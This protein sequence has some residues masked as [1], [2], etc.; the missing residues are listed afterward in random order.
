MA[1]LSKELR[2]AL[3]SDC[4]HS[5][6]PVAASLSEGD[7]DALIELVDPAANPLRRQKAVHLL[8]GSGRESAVP[9]IVRLLPVIDEAE[10]CRAISALGRLGG[11]EAFQA[12]VGC[13]G[14][15]SPQVRKFVAYALRQL[16]EPG[17]DA[18]LAKIER[19]EQVDWV[20]SLVKRS[21]KAR[22]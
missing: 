18:A 16:D 8:G 22:R 15:A 11:P 6:E 13:A 3:D 5:L 19:E 10:R 1:R 20:R 12:I 2:A 7:L 14:D 4:A 17:A 9:A 21:R